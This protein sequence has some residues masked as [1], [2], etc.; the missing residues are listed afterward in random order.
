MSLP[1]LP[2]AIN[3]RLRS[4]SNTLASQ[5]VWRQDGNW[6]KRLLGLVKTDAPEVTD[7]VGKTDP[8]A[9]SE[10]M[11]SLAAIDLAQELGRVRAPKLALFGKNDPVIDASQASVFEEQPVHSRAMVMDRSRHFPMLEEATAFHRLL[12]DFL[13]VGQDPQ[14]LELKE[15]WHRRTH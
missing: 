5:L 6:A 15:M 11:R 10:S 7:E 14:N 4:F 12:R 9:I 8:E 2:S 13:V 3:G 1:L